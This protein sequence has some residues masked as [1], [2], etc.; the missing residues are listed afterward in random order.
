MIYLHAVA[1]CF[2]GEL[3]NVGEND[4]SLI[5]INKTAQWTVSR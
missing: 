4:I 5:E 2:F 1:K 3:A